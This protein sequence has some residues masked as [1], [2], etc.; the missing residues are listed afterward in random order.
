MQLYNHQCVFKNVQYKVIVLLL[1]HL[2]FRVRKKVQTIN[3]DLKR[4]P[5]A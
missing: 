4:K 2:E 1:L 5:E 3:T